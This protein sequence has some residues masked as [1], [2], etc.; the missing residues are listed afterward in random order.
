MIADGHRV[1][2]YYGSVNDAALCVDDTDRC[3]SDGDVET[4]M[5]M[6]LRHDEGSCWG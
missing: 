4:N 1:A 2:F 3:R 6:M 5:V